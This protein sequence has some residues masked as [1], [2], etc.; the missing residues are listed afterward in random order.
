MISNPGAFI[1]A[2]DPPRLDRRSNERLRWAWHRA[3]GAMIGDAERLHAVCLISHP[4]S[5]LHSDL[6]LEPLGGLHD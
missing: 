1:V 4:L 2:P 6:G 3:V 5:A